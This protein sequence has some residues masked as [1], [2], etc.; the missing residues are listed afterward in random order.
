MVECTYRRIYI[1]GSIYTGDCTHDGVYIQGSFLFFKFFFELIKA[2]PSAY[3]ANMRADAALQVYFSD[4]VY[5]EL[6]LRQCHDRY[7]FSNS[8]KAVVFAARSL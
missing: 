3:E 1:Y 2:T 5:C 4:I 7:S 6:L 8:I